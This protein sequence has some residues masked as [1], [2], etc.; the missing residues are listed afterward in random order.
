MAD[1]LAADRELDN[2]GLSRGWTALVKALVRP[3]LVVVDQELF[4]YRLQVTSR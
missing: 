1:D 3:R 4:D 2:V